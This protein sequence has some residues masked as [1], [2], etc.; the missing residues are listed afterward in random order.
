VMTSPG[1]NTI[2]TLERIA[3]LVLY[4]A[5]LLI[6]VLGGVFMCTILKSNLRSVTMVAVLNLTIAHFVFLLTVPFRIHYFISNN[7]IFTSGFCKIVSGM[8]HI[9]MYMAFT[10]YVIILSVRIMTFYKGAEQFTF[11]RNLH[12]LG[13]SVTMWTL[14]CIVV[15]MLLFSYGSNNEVESKCFTFGAMIKKPGVQELNYIISSIFIIV[16]CIFCTFQ[17]KIILSIVRKYGSEI[18]VQQE[19][20]A[21]MKSLCFISIMLVCF[22]PYHIF[23]LKYLQEPEKDEVINEIFLAVS[24]LCCID[25]LIFTSRGI[26]YKTTL[27]C[28]L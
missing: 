9:H 8:I 25:L 12:S 22:V 4:T 21:Q 24:S 28:C 18:G 6:G 27:I 15:L 23:R 2:T 20:W 16:P 10:I 13:A 5:V 7:W 1:N 26:C 19:F 17:G 3:L 14:I 11:H